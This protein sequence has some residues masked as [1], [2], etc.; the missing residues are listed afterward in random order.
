MKAKLTMMEK[1]VVRIFNV[2]SPYLMRVLKYPSPSEDRHSAFPSSIGRS[3][4]GCWYF[5]VGEDH[6]MYRSYHHRFSREYDWEKEPARIYDICGHEI[7]Y[8]EEGWIGF[9]LRHLWC[10]PE[11]DFWYVVKEAWQQIHV[12]RDSANK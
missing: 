10:K 2:F 8:A 5:Q 9:D 12:V 6:P 3:G 11:H 1:I 7:T 4:F